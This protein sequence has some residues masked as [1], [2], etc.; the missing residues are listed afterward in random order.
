MTALRVRE[1]AELCNGL[2][3][4]F[5]ALEQR[6]VGEWRSFT[7][8]AYKGGARKRTI[9]CRILSDIF[10]SN[11]DRWHDTEVAALCEIAFDYKDIISTDAVKTARRGLKKRWAG[12]RVWSPKDSVNPRRG[13]MSL[14]AGWVPGHAVAWM[15]VSGMSVFMVTASLCGTPA[16]CP[17]EH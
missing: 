1:F 7:R 3:A 14:P 17:A 2:N 5:A 4:T 10:H 12:L 16:H 13:S 15:A 9:F 8:S 6:Q 11:F